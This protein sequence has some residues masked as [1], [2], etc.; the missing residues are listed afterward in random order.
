MKK[1]LM[2]LMLLMP[3]VASAEEEGLKLD[4]A[5]VNVQDYASIQRGAKLFTNYCLTCHSANYM[6]YN[7]MHD[8]GLTDDEIKNNLMFA[9]EKVGETMHVS[10]R[11]EEAAKWF[12]AAP[13]DLSVISRARGADWLYTY[14]RSFY[15]DPSRP[16]GWN[17][18]VFKNVGMPFVLYGLQGEQELQVEK[19]MENGKEV[20][21]DKLVL[22]KPGTMTEPEY[23]RAV[24]DLVN[25][26]VWM[27]EPSQSERKHLGVY[28][29]AF[30][31][32]FFVVA[33]FLKKEYWKDIH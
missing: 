15:L 16:T 33:Y 31:A 21:E 9:A 29:M 17:N 23:D 18:T 20:E 7:R 12:G 27:G 30:L 8:I 3:V 11:P 22:A 32:F 25:Y 4:K 10:M 2:M 14:L 13:P 1:F 26:L 28:V 19:K 24:A 6:R 5:P